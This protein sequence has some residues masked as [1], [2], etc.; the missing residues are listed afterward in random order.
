MLISPAPSVK[1]SPV[2]TDTLPE[3]ANDEPLTILIVPLDPF[4]DAL[5][6]IDTSPL[7]RSEASPLRTVTDPPI[8]PPL[9]AAKLR[10]PP[11]L[12]ES[13]AFIR[14]EPPDD[15]DEVDPA[16]MATS[17]PTLPTEFPA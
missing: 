3:F 12:A 8:A 10:S 9:P 5:D 14:T 17:P 7:E 15:N 4:L 11:N 2:R 1:E 13:P 16:A 6:K